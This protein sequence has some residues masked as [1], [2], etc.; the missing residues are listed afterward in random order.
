[1]VVG[2]VVA[3]VCGRVHK[4]QVTL[5]DVVPGR[6]ALAQR[7][8]VGFATPADAPRDCDFVFHTSASAAGLATALGLAGDEAS[9]IELSWYGSGDVPVP[10]G[11]AFHSPRLRLISHQGG[12]GAPPPRAEVTHP[13]RPPPA[14]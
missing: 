6:A 12:K 5:G 7:L 10:L 8:G 4:T 2:A 9:V 13:P 1:G 14:P 11:G 3:W